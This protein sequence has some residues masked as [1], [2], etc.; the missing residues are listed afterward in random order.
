MTLLW[1][2]E[3]GSG[4]PDTLQDNASTE[5][6]DELIDVIGIHDNQRGLRGNEPLNDAVIDEHG[7]S[8]VAQT[9]LHAGVACSRWFSLKLRNCWNVIKY[10]F[11]RTYI[12]LLMYHWTRQSRAVFWV[13]LGIF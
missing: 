6:D 13:I 2:R 3:S 10:H 9:D 7:A 5:Q 11:N 4:T 8:A 1:Q 12:I